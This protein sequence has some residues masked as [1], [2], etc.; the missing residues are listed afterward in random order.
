MSSQEKEIDLQ[1]L[2][3]LQ[4]EPFKC[5]AFSG[6]GAKGTIYS[7]AH[8]ALVD[9]GVLN[10]LEAVAGS[11]AGA[12][13]ATAIATGISK[14]DF[15]KICLETNLKGL[16]GGGLLTKD[17]KPLYEL[18]QNIVSKNIDK[19]LEDIELAKGI[20]ASRAT[21]I[22]KEISTIADYDPDSLDDPDSRINELKMQLG[23][24]EEAKKNNYN[25]LYDLKNRSEQ[26]KPITFK[27][28]DMLHVIDP[29]KFKDLII[30][31]TNKNTGELTIFD[32]RNSPD[33]EIALA[34]R[35]S[36][37]IPLVF[38]AVE[39]E[40]VKYVDG[41]YRDN[42]PTKYFLDS[43]KQPKLI[44]SSKQLQESKKQGRVLS[45]AFGAYKK[46]DRANI[47][48]YSSKENKCNMNAIVKFLANVV[49]KTLS[50][51]GG[52]F[53]YTKEDDKTYEELR[54]NALN[55]VLLDTKDVS[56][57]SFDK[58]Q[59]DAKYLHIKGSIQTSRYFENFN[60][61]KSDPNLS[62]KEFML[63]VYELAKS[64]SSTKSWTD[65]LTSKVAPPK[66]L[67][68]Y[69]EPKAWKNKEVGDVLGKFIEVASCAGGEK[70]SSNT[71]VMNNI[72]TQLNDPR[73][74]DSVKM[75]FNNLL[76]KNINNKT[77]EKQDFQNLLNTMK[78][79]ISKDKDS[80]RS[81]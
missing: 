69:C 70:L 47:A 58:A 36:S 77:Y 11:S 32:S 53:T 26:N 15:Q 2:Q 28:I 52:S 25:Q 31:A 34:A 9:S 18:L 63:E 24:L 64:E 48:I 57:L 40:G 37:S 35:A 62:V 75:H 29:V 43:K 56:T 51:V 16:L 68:S 42:L 55:T 49:F 13:T 14:E 7:G 17:G 30:T 39:I 10:G 8:E 76:G 38:E 74:S 80:G 12:I 33:V 5:A 81:P 41:G 65:F 67:L 66:S 4:E 60:I 50:R 19:Y 59:A 23:K 21:E 61:G 6:G 78:K 3:R 45:L 79:D 73:T 72:I 44:E 20:C 54:K 46:D 22:T 1:E 71:K 27:D